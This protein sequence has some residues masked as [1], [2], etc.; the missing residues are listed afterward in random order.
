MIFF[1]YMLS[2]SDK[3]RKNYTVLTR[4]QLIKECKSLDFQKR[5]AWAQYYS[6][7]DSAVKV[8]VKLRKCNKDLRDLIEKS[9]SDEK[10]LI[11]PKHL[12]EAFTKCE[13]RWTCTL[14]LCGF[15][16]TKEIHST[17]CGHL[18]HK[19]C[20]KNLKNSSGSKKNKCPNCRA[21]I[22]IN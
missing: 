18:F 7:L 15:E 22:W 12:L 3:K 10:E 11:I 13:G 2:M 14:C 16:E 21:D 17:K 4:D 6:E 19:D 5:A 9:L 20:M 8:G 1:S